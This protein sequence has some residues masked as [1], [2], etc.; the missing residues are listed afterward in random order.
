MMATSNE[1]IAAI[2]KLIAEGYEVT[3][4]EVK[5]NNIMVISITKNGEEVGFVM[6]VVLMSDTLS[7]PVVGSALNQF[8]DKVNN[9]WPAKESK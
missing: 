4:K 6:D 8:V 9:G 3:F 7:K 5:P 2:K 1:K